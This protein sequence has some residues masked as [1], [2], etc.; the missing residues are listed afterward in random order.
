MTPTIVTYSHANRAEELNGTRAA[1]EAAGLPITH[2]QIQTDP[3]SQIGNRLNAHA[4]LKRAID[5]H[6]KGAGLLMI[7]DDIRPSPHLPA[8]LEYLA[9]QGQPTTLYTPNQITRQAPEHLA[10]VMRGERRLTTGETY[11]IR[12]L[13]AWWG[14]QAVWL[15]WP[16]AELLA[17]HP[18]ADT[19]QRGPGPWDTFVRTALLEHGLQLWATAPSLVQHTGARN[20]Q[21]PSR[22]P[23]RSASYDDRVKPPTPGD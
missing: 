21:A 22:T 6:R 16:T 19:T 5:R 20:L 8:W 1:F 12:A 10:A 9:G 2:E 4:A 13:H 14:A 11:P 17:V 3:P 23:H 18:L 15:P 7:E